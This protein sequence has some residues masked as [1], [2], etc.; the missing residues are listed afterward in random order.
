MLGNLLTPELTSL[1]ALSPSIDQIGTQERIARIQARSIKG[2]AKIQG[3]RMA[4]SMIDLTTLEGK[5]TPQKSV[6]FATKPNICT[7]KYLIYQQLLP[8]VFTQQW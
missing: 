2:T 4:L 8:F 3:L 6:S 5:D 7:T 1:L